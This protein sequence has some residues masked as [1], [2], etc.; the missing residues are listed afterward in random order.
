MKYNFEYL[1]HKVI[2]TLVK[3][4]NGH[5]CW[6]YRVYDKYNDHVLS[7]TCDDDYDYETA[8][9]LAREAIEDNINHHGDTP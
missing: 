5:K 1:D 2:L 7:H 6:A 4:N 8:C 3:I 9:D